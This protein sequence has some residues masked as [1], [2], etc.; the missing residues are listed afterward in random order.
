MVQLHVDVRESSGSRGLL[1]LDQVDASHSSLLPLPVDSTAPF[2]RPTSSSPAKGDTF[3]QK[4]RVPLA[5]C[6]ERFWESLPE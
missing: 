3:P 6:L 4:L 2:V 5:T 1:G